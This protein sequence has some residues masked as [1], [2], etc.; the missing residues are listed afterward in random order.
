MNQFPNEKFISQ[1]IQN[2][3]PNF[4]SEEGELFID[5]VRAYYE[6]LEQSGNE[7]SDT[8]LFL[9]YQNIDLAPDD[10]VVHFQKKYIFGLSEE[11]LINKKL[12]IKHIKD[13]YRSKSSI[14]GWKLLYRLL[15]NEDV[16]VYLPSTDILEPSSGTWFQ[17]KYLEITDNGSLNS[18]VGKKIVGVSSGTTALVESLA[19]EPINKTIVCVLYISN[20]SPKESD[21]T[22]GEKIVLADQDV[23]DV[24]N[25]PTIIGSLSSIEITSGGQGFDV[26]N[27]L[28]VV[29]KD[30][31]TGQI[32]TTG[33]DSDVRVKKTSKG[34][35]S[36]F[37][38]IIQGGSGYSSNPIKVQYRANTDTTGTG[39]SFSVGT[40][41]DVST[42]TFN[43][44]ILFPYLNTVLNA[45]SYNFPLNPTSNIS[46]PM[47]E[48]LQYTTSSYG[49]IASLTNIAT[50]NS[51]TN[52][53]IIGLK[54]GFRSPVIQTGLTF[55]TNSSIVT[56][57]NT[58][59]TT[60]L[61][62]NDFIAIG[63]TS[64]VNSFE[65]H[66]IDYVTNNTHLVLKG[67]TTLSNTS[68]GFYR[69]Y[70]NPFEANLASPED[71][72]DDDTTSKG[73]NAIVTGIPSI[74]VGVVDTV[75]LVNA[76]KGYRE[77]EILKMYLFGG[78]THPI[79]NVGGNGYSNNEPLIF[80]GGNTQYKPKG[81]IKTNSNGS[82]VEIIMQS[83]GS[84]HKTIPQISVK[85]I[86]GTGANI[87][88]TLADFNT[89]TVVEGRAKLAG[90]GKG[91]GY[92]TTTR[93]FLSSDKHIQD[94]YFYQAYSYQLKSSINFDKY[95][96]MLTYVF[97]VAGYEMF[98]SNYSVVHESS[99]S[100]VLYESEVTI[101]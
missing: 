9:D 32:L 35:G 80:S 12:L 76:G 8:R 90:I 50:G 15:F 75:S 26:G 95:K 52:P 10:F 63:N 64:N 81:T 71:L 20:V 58:T 55:T 83:Y 46:S 97:H 6:W 21:F 100:D 78:I 69:L 101:T 96:Q 13:V 68:T 73:E 22:K 1:F 47:T 19:Y 37:F 44:D 87:T 29:H 41:S 34:I 18:Y 14:R 51:Y 33:I 99:A 91:A 93:S 98:G 92:W 82:I 56:G 66:I 60:Y 43:T 74:G 28:R 88:T 84:S 86:R 16:E 65:N 42:Y 72:L 3:F 70:I 38:D 25:A 7:L 40:L 54:E 11:T 94:S 4:Y 48:Y 36:I 79:I 61:S 85:T 89:A 24:L 67:P 5:F 27:I 39:A 23:Q 45:N 59:F 30:P 57:S 53:L 77:D 62:N 31:L 17:P 2:Q 49:K